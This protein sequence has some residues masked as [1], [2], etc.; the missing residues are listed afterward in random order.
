MSLL[1]IFKS[2]KGTNRKKWI[3]IAIGFVI[4][5][6]LLS[7]F[8]YKIYQNMEEQK[9]RDISIAEQSEAAGV[10]P[11]QVLLDLQFDDK[12]DASWFEIH[13][14]NAEEIIAED[15]IEDGVFT[16]KGQIQ[17]KQ[18]LQQGKFIHFQV[19]AP[20]FNIEGPMFMLDLVNQN[21]TMESDFQMFRFY[22]EHNR[23]LSLGV[24]K[25]MSF[26]KVDQKDTAMLMKGNMKVDVVVWLDEQ[27]NSLRYIIFDTENENNIGYVGVVMED[28]WQNESWFLHIELDSGF[29]GGAVSDEELY[30]D[31]VFL[32]VGSGSLFSYMSEKYCNLSG[33]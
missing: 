29:W 3:V 6:S 26:A 1:I 27:D 32:T 20:D 25:L 5:A 11:Y 4:V 16:L 8:G 21:W 31:V 24:N 13:G 2:P 19:I 12:E 23:T 9:D 28:G 22:F 10:E 18:A 7:V 30:T 17:L 33:K 15:C 14:E